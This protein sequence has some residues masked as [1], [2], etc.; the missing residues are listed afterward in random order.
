MHDGMKHTLPGLESDTGVHLYIQNTHNMSKATVLKAHTRQR[1]GS[2]ALGRLRKEGLIPAVVYGKKQPALNIRLDRKSV[3][4]V[5]SHSASEQILVTLE[6]E[7]TKETKLALIQDVQHNPL[8]GLILHMDFHAVQE[9]EILHAHVPIDLIGDAIGV[10]AGGLLEFLTHSVNITC[11]PLDLPGKIQLDI[12]NLGLG[13]SV[14]ISDLVVPNGVKI[15]ADGDIV[16]ALIAELKAAP[17]PTAEELAAAAAAPAKKGAAKK[18]AA[19]AAAAPAK[20]AA[21]K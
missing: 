1:T 21:K 17:V 19:P 13:Q 6:I 2:G 4:D 16:V 10:K 7:D 9:N 14:H 8:T 15:E 11:L 5:L 12:S 20:K 18:A 3:V